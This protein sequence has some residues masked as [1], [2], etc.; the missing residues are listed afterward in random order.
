M[1][2]RTDAIDSAHGEVAAWGHG[3]YGERIALSH[4]AALLNE[5]RNTDQQ[6]ARGRCSLSH[7][8]LRG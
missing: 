6:F 3:V 7:G 2:D 5:V 4:A 8:G 1:T